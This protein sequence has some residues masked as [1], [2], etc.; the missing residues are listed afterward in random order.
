MSKLVDFQKAR[1]QRDTYRYAALVLN[2]W[3]RLKQDDRR[4]DKDKRDEV[5]KRAKDAL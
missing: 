3:G 4:V 5:R 1:S 2:A